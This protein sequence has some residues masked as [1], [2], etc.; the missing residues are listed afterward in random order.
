VTG[1]GASAFMTVISQRACYLKHVLQQ[2]QWNGELQNTDES[3]AMDR[4]GLNSK[5][6][7]S[8]RGWCLSYVW[9]SE[10]RL[11]HLGLDFGMHSN[12][13]LLI[14][15]HNRSDWGLRYHSASK[16]IRAGRRLSRCESSN[17]REVGILRYLRK[18]I[19][20]CR[21]WNGLGIREIKET[22]Q[23]CKVKHRGKITCPGIRGPAR[24]WLRNL[25]NENQS[26]TASDEDISEKKL[27]SHWS[28]TTRRMTMLA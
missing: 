20:A 10:S 27:G 6:N 2:L 28:L 19:P 23:F 14:K 26:R 7:K 16:E 8:I 22:D 13:N 15:F 1:F 21:W 25:R 12:I 17:W 5:Q 18:A 3:S 11:R 24:H 9:N 4:S